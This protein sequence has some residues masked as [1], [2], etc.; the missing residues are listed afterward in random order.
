M[1]KK[2]AT[3]EREEEDLRRFMLVVLCCGTAESC[4][5]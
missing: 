2:L 4:E 1:M 5:H 3:M